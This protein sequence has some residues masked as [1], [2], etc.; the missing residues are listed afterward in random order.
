MLGFGGHNGETQFSLAMEVATQLGLLLCHRFKGTVLETLCSE[1]GRWV[2][3]VIKQDNG[4]FIACCIYMDTTLVHP[5]G[6][7]S[8]I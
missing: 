5:I 8:L 1:E 2:C 4:T 3:A 6:Q 7:C